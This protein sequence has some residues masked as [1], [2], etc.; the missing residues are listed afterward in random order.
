MALQ[1]KTYSKTLSSKNMTLTLTLTENSVNT[2]N[3]TSNITYKLVIKS[4]GSYYF[5]DYSHGYNV[6]LNGTSVANL[7]HVANKNQIS[8]AA[9]AS[10]TICSGTTNVTHNADGKLDMSVSYSFYTGY[11]NTISGTGTMTLTSTSISSGVVYIGN[12]S[13]FDA[14]EI[15][16]GN[17]TSWDRYIP[18]IGNGTD[19]DTCS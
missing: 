6:T 2:A 18:Y 15:Y 9:G 5:S 12:G 19:W 14:Y 4:N 11:T 16:I 13:S 10:L 7:T 8:L 3:N 17:G 1:T